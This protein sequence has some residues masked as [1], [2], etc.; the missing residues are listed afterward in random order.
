MPSGAV[1]RFAVLL[2]A[3][4]VAAGAARGQEVAGP[5]P[6]AAKPGTSN[7]TPRIVQGVATF[8]LDGHRDWTSTGLTARKGEVVRIRAWGRIRIAGAGNRLIDPAGFELPTLARIAPSLTACQLIAVVGEDNNDYVAI[9]KEAEFRAQH[10]GTIYLTINQVNTF[11]NTGD[12]DVRVSVGNA[13][14]LAFGGPTT[15]TT[16]GTPPPAVQAPDSLDTN[17]KVVTVSPN[18]D[19]TN[20]YLTI[21]RGDTIVVDADGSVTLD[22]A[23]HTA[24]PDGITLKDPGRLIVDKPTGALIAVVGI[25]NNDFIFLGSKG[26]F[27]SARN[28]LLFLGVN[29]ESLA[30]NSGSF[31]ARVKIERAAK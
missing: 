11:G 15:P 24:G 5:P 23:G 20:T 9:G 19:W 6:G 1:H 3:L 17:E 30:N 14:G 7:A 2:A 27:T 13:S 28:G 12:F 8:K 29:E 4:I 31:R 21:R 26:R 18:L 25:D 10:D 16:I 22:L